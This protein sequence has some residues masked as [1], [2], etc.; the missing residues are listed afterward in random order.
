MDMDMQHWI[1]GLCSSNGKNINKTDSTRLHDAVDTLKL[2]SDGKKTKSR[3][4]KSGCR[5]DGFF[6]NL[7]VG[8]DD[9]GGNHRSNSNKNT[10][11]TQ[12]EHQ[13]QHQLPGE[14]E[15]GYPLA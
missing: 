7:I 11:R 1:Q 3:L 8:G 4:P 6:D 5:V 13:Q 9:G 12:H 2:F 15:A 10:N 14:A